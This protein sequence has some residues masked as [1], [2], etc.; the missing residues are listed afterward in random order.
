MTGDM[1]SVSLVWPGVPLCRATMLDLAPSCLQERWLCVQGCGLGMS[2]CFPA[3]DHRHH[4]TCQDAPRWAPTRPGL[5]CSVPLS[6]VLTLPSPVPSAVVAGPAPASTEH[7]M[8]SPAAL[9][10]HSP[11]LPPGTRLSS[12]AR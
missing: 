4:D 9:W 7:A 12:P 11:P 5:L 8:Q 3:D 2:W 6:A 1:T 10:S